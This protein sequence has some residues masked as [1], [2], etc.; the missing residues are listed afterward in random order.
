MCVHTSAVF[1]LLLRKVCV[2]LL[3]LGVA[4]KNDIVGW[5]RPASMESC[6][7]AIYISPTCENTNN[8]GE[9]FRVTISTTPCIQ[10]PPPPLLVVGRFRRL[11]PPGGREDNSLTVVLWPRNPPQ[12]GDCVEDGD[13]QDFVANQRT[14]CQKTVSLVPQ[15]SFSPGTLPGGSFL[16]EGSLASGT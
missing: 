5:S 4:K 3:F 8:G 9:M 12:G 15:N 2:A 13:R 6:C 1:S 14:A 10:V 16:I 11:T 7:Q